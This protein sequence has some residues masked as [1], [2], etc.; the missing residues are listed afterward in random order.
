MSSPWDG[1]DAAVSLPPPARAEAL[2]GVLDSL[3]SVS[4][5]EHDDVNELRA[6][7]LAEM[8]SLDNAYLDEARSAVDA[9]ESSGR[10]GWPNYYLGAA[11]VHWGHNEEALVRLGRVPAGFFEERDLGWRALHIDEMVAVA[12]L[13]LGQHRQAAVLVDRIAAALGDRG[14]EDDLAPPTALVEA[15]LRHIDSPHTQ[16]IRTMLAVLATSIDLASWTGALLASR[17]DK[18]LGD[19]STAR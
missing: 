13:E 2:R 19:T 18:A 16:A 14:D 15:L 4:D 9:A 1:F 7:V 8:A 6:V 12:R 17:V 10:L 11:L 5:V 3:H